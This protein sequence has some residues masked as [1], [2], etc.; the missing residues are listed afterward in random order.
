MGLVTSRMKHYVLK[1]TLLAGIVLTYPDVFPD[2]AL[3]Y[4]LESCIFLI[5]NL[6]MA[7]GWGGTGPEASNCMSAFFTSSMY[8]CSY[9]TGMLR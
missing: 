9:L 7:G 8:S 2:M 6:S 5:V 1:G 3:C 4:Q